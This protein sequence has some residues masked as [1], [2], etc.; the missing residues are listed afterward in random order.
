MATVTLEMLQRLMLD[1]QAEIK[2]AR[3]EVATL[4]Q[5]VD[6]MAQTMIDVRRDVRSL[7]GEVATLGA[8]IAGHSCR[9]EQIE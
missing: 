6:G 9:L 7:Q 5:K 3:G 8:A 1:M 2:G 4:T